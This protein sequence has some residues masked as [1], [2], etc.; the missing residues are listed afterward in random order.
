MARVLKGAPVA[1]ALSEKLQ[2]RVSYLD[3]L[4]IKPRLALVRVG[5]RA[6]DLAYERGILKRA[7]KLGFAVEKFLLPVD[8]T[9]DELLQVIDEINGRADIHA[10]LMFRPLPAQFDEDKVCAAL[11]PQKD[12][13]G[14]TL[15]SYAG[16]YAHLS[17]GFPPCT[18]EAVICLLEHYGYPLDGSEICVIGR[19]LVIGKPVS[20]MLQAKQATVTMCHTHTKNLAAHTKA[21][22]IVV[23][24]AG[25]PHTLAADGVREGQIVVDVGINWDEQAHKLVGDVDFDKVEPL[26]AALTPVPGGV[27]SLTT[28]VLAQHVIEAAE[29]T[30]A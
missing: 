20:L 13:D 2:S 23:V 4:G 5:E 8:A 17:L 21:A 3:E 19:S 15:G 6:D 14:I 26:V 25:H 27:G 16:V 1:L 22:D 11:D 9:Q 28:A 24:A 29:R 12:V 18:A 7:D 30:V 10:G